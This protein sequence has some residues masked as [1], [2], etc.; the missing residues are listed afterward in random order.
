MDCIHMNLA[1]IANLTR[2]QLLSQLIANSLL[3]Q[4]TSGKTL[5]Q[6]R[7]LNLHNVCELLLAQRIKDHHIINNV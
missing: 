6:L 5:C 1:T 7:N 2:Q 3:D 4:T